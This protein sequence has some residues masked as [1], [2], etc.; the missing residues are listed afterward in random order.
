MNKYEVIKK[1]LVT[2]KSTLLQG[3][4]N[5]YVF[6][7]NPKATK[8]DI[9]SAVEGLFKVNVNKVNVA[10]FSGKWKRVGKNTGKTSNWKKAIVSLAKGDSIEFFEG[11]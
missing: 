1:P 2:E 11:V 8:K 6:A 4:N 7:V 3:M 9:K 5:Q 10:N